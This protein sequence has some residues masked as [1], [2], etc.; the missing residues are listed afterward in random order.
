MFDES[1]AEQE[2]RVTEAQARARAEATR[3]AM[4]EVLREGPMSR[5]DL[6]ARLG[7]DAP[8]SVVNYH[9]AVLVNDREI[10]NEEGVYRL[11]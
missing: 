1:D 4:L 3:S 8:V 7:E 6:R 2:R 11:A 5:A 9:L 10:V